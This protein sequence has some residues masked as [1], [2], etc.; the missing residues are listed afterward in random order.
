MGDVIAVD[1]V[2][3]TRRSNV[4]A[5]RQDQASLERLG[6]VLHDAGWSIPGIA[7]VFDAIHDF[8]LYLRADAHTRRVVDIYFKCTGQV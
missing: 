4:P 6:S 1:F 2:T 3:K 5:V 7:G 8:D